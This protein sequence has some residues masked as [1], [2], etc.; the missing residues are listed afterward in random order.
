MNGNNMENYIDYIEERKRKTTAALDLCPPPIRDWLIECTTGSITGEPSS[1]NNDGD[2]VEWF[3]V[4]QNSSHQFFLGVRPDGV[5]IRK[6][7]GEEYNQECQCTY[8]KVSLTVISPGDI[9]NNYWG[10]L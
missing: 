1:T 7:T 10:H 9:F 5:F 6:A 2:L 3:M 4:G 8:F